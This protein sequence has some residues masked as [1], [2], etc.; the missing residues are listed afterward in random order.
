M[1]D[2]ATSPFRLNLEQQRKR[3]RELQ[4]AL[5]GGDAAAL[6]R[7]RVHH[8][9]ATQLPPGALTRLSEAQ[10]VIAR[11]LGLPSWPKLKAHT[12]ALHRSR[13][14]ISSREPAPDADMPTLHIRCGSDIVPTLREAGFAGEILE[15]TNPLC[16]GPVTEEDSWLDRRAAFLDETFATSLNRSPAEMEAQLRAAEDALEAAPGRYLRI[17]L[18]FEHDSYDQLVLAR[19]LARFA[20]V[21]PAHLELVFI[22]HYPG[23][24]RFIGLGQ[25]PPEALRLLWSGRQEVKAAALRS[26]AEAW[27][28]LRA[29]NPT[30]LARLAHEGTPGLPSLAPA[31]RRHCQELPWQ[32]DG[33]GLTERLILQSLA[34]QPRDFSSL[35]RDVTAREPL[36]WLGDAMLLPF[37]AALKTGAV[38]GHGG[39]GATHWAREEFSITPLGRALL[40]GEADWMTLCPP[41]RWVGGVHIAPPAPAWR[42]CDETG[43]VRLTA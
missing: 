17:V 24:A 27:A 12:E 6:A 31:L 1:T 21:A 35:F 14:A 26:G 2:H 20:Q 41:A 25:L 8:P 7:F 3:A 22:G 42:W 18:W 4:R 39:N 13:Q 15:Y 34:D 38:A 43:S 30:A 28:A 36:P 23:S 11:E 10:L 37:L 5:L 33:L 40:S 9:R 16:L 19:C 29:P 32:R